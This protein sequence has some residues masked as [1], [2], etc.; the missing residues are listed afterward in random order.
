[1]SGLSKEL[2]REF[3]RE[4][5]FKSIK[6]IENA[7]IDI[8]KDTIQEALETEIEEEFG[9]YKYDLAS[10]SNN[11][12]KNE[13][14]KKTVKSSIGNLDLLVPGDREDAYQPNIV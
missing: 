4:G 12:I 3:F 8:F 9:Y 1:M 5:N 2:F 11:N 14:Y 13:K 10:K 6:D 7:L